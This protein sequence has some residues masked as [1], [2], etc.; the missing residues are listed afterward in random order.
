MGAIQT[1]RWP[2]GPNASAVLRTA[3]VCWG[4][5]EI[6]QLANCAILLAR[7]PAAETGPLRSHQVTPECLSPVPR[8]RE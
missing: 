2:V 7:D 5:E 3:H 4:G 1:L 6:A 8:M